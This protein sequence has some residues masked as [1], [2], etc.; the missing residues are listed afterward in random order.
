[1]LAERPMILDGIMLALSTPP[2]RRDLL[3]PVEK[4]GSVP[5]VWCSE[6][7]CWICLRKIETWELSREGQP[8]SRTWMNEAG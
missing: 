2:T 5:P 6:G 4:G 1:M 7:C 8:F 3:K